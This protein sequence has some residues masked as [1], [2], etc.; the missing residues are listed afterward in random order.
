MA[1]YWP[2]APG[3]YTLTSGFGPRDGGMHRGID[4]A[5]PEGTP[6][7]AAQAG[8]VVHI[9]AA[10]GFGQWIVV[11]HPT[12]AGSGTTVYGHMWNAFETGLSRGDWVE[13]GQH[14]AF[15]GNNGDTTGAHLHFEYHPTVWAAGSQRDPV[16]WLHGAL[17]PGQ[18]TVRGARLRGVGQR[19]LRAL[20][21]TIYADVSE[22][23]VPVDDSYPYRVI[24]IRSNDGDYRDK[25]WDDNYG[26]CRRKCDEGI[27]D[28]FIVYFVWYPNWE[29][30]V[31]TIKDLVGEPHPRMAVMID[32]ESWG[33]KITG[34]QSA[35]LNG[36][37]WALAEW[38]G[39]HRRV[40]AYGNTSDL[41]GLWPNKPD[42]LG[43]VLA[44]WGF[45]P[46]YPG[47]IAHQYT[48]GGGYGNGDTLPD[49]CLPFGNCDMNSADGRSPVEFAAACGIDAGFAVVGSRSRSVAANAYGDGSHDAAVERDALLGDSDAIEL[50]RQCAATSSDPIARRRAELVLARLQQFADA[51]LTPATPLPRSAANAPARKAP[52]KAPAKKAPEPKKP[53]EKDAN[54]G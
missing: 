20:S 32:I 54:K 8:T 38:L 49:G 9:G 22:H 31:E 6:M 27:L 16:P 39:D 13:A 18:P 46:G 11:D 42:D 23:Q 3:T 1:R 12:E 34:D 45:N 44:A 29:L 36:A 43:I 7:Y 53:R 50:V 25:H 15:V 28:F 35:G 52:A 48:D 47:K 10:T 2:M 5:A 41:N 40:I 24:A 51:G 21:D 37:Y 26:W 33:G 19:A 14:I 17:Q 30:G 4:L